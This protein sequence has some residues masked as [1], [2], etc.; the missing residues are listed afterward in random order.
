[1]APMRMGES[2]DWADTV[3][4][5]QA[6]ATATTVSARLTPENIPISSTVCIG[7]NNHVFYNGSVPQ[8]TVE[9][10]PR[11]WMRQEPNTCQKRRD[12]HLLSRPPAG[13]VFQ[14]PAAIIARQYLCQR[15]QP[16]TEWENPCI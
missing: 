5:A 16:C 3:V 10:S 7:L 12:H 8:I 13:Q 1:M 11:L 15:E 6:A 14:Q 9:Y 2:S 4:P